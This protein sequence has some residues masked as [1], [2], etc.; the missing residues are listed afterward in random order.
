MMF[1]DD[2][3]EWELLDALD[4]SDEEYWQR[5]EE[6]FA[7]EPDLY[8]LDGMTVSALPGTCKGVSYV[9]LYRT[10]HK[11]A[12]YLI[13]DVIY[14]FDGGRVKATAWRR[15]DL[16]PLPIDPDRP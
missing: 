16:S 10:D 14:N 11:G 8:D 6:L 12:Y 3:D 2:F 13:G 7:K 9:E 5:A 4:L 1:T 15:W